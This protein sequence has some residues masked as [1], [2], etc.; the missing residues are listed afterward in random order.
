MLP[1]GGLFITIF[2]GWV[3]D[4]KI[5]RDEVGLYK[6]DGSPKLTYKFFRFFIKFIAPLAILAVII[7]VILGKDFS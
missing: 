2:V 5:C 1:V 3:L 4:K 7:A 6:P